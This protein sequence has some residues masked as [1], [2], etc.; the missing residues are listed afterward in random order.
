VLTTDPDYSFVRLPRVGKANQRIEE[1]SAQWNAG[2][3]IKR[4]DQQAGQFD[5]RAKRAMAGPQH[6]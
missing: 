5:R 6:G 1:K 3:C 2:A 4:E